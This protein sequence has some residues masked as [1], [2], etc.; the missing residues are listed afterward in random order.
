MARLDSLIKNLVELA[1]TEET[2]KEASV[3]AFSIRE[4]AQANV[5]AFQPLAQSAGKGIE[6]QIV[7]E[8]EVKGVQDNLFRLFSILL[9]NG[10]KY[11]DPGGTI[12]LTLTQRGRTVCLSVSNPCAGVDPAQLPRYFDRFY[13]ADSSR[14]RAT[15]GYGIG[16]STAKAIVSRHRGRISVRYA[17]GE[18]TFTVLLPQGLKKERS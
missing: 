18:I 4:I 5:D 16:L 7:P 1:R 2:V 10:V 14:A 3:T 12:R 6:A 15:G 8:V 11:C 17:G 13:R 9:D